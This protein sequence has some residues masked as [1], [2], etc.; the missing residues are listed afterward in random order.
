MGIAGKSITTAPKALRN[1]ARSFGLGR[2]VPIDLVRGLL[3][4]EA[5]SCAAA[6]PLLHAPLSG[7]LPRAAEAVRIGML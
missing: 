2:R 3:C 6:L 5:K 7:D 1:P 4:G